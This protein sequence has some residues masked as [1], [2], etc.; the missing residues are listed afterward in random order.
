MNRMDVASGMVTAKVKRYIIN[1][2]PASPRLT[3]NKYFIR[4]LLLGVKPE[5]L[6]PNDF[7]P[8]TTYDLNEVLS[9]FF[10]L[11]IGSPQ[12]ET[13][14]SFSLF[15]FRLNQERI[16]EKIF[17]APPKQLYLRIFFSQFER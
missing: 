7:Q 15:L 11:I 12:G 2:I 14:S 9:S 3:F 10:S 8:P 13:G 4:I 16:F 5:S 17:Y 1:S 6:W